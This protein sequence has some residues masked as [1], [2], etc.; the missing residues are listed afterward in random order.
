MSWAAAAGGEPQTAGPR[1]R[2]VVGPLARV[3]TFRPAFDRRW[4][5]VPADLGRSRQRAEA[6]L[7]AWRRWLGPA[8]LQ[9]TQRSVAGREAAA[10]ACAAQ[11]DYST[12]K[13]TVWV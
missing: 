9:F 13:R 1:G 5:A 7:E 11:L 4:V 2:S 3:L 10:Q 12:S 8:E 6:Y